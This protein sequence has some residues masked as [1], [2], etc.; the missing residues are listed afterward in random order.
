MPEDFLVARNPE[1]GTTLP[2]LL[3]IPLGANGI[4]L[5]AREKWP[6]TSKVYCHRAVGWP[7]DPEILEAVPVRSC[8]RRGA[9]I[10]LVLDRG[11]ENRSQFV[12]TR[13]RGGR[14]AIFWQTARTARQA[15]PR[16]S[17]PTARASGVAELA[18][19][20]DSR[21]R[22]A[23]KFSQQQASTTRRA[24]P[25]GDYAVER[26]G[27]VVAAVERKSLADLVATLTSGRMR[28]LLAELAELPRAAVVVEDRYSRVFALEHVRPAVVA[29]ALAECQAR[30][31]QV[32]IIFCETRALAQEWTYRFLAAALR[33]VGDEAGG[34]LRMAELAPATAPS[35]AEIRTWARANGH[36]VSDRGRIPAAVLA[37]FDRRNT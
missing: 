14:E 11:R 5:K 31:P 19:L 25:A 29:D 33:E 2:Y 21:E 24:L 8:V 4:V 7:A 22:Y 35:S 26:D 6:R 17:V 37:A 28:Y 30:F 16:V 9:A 23:W 18:I 27:A 1:E 12:L 13:V 15:R 34:D 32:P 20:V 3:R 36:A 10:D